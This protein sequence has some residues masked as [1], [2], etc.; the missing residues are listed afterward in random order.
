M[1][2]HSGGRGTCIYKKRISSRK[3]ALA[4]AHRKTRE[5]GELMQAY[6]CLACHSWHIGHAER[7][8]ERERRY[9]GTALGHASR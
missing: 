6:K 2:I 7:Y 4:A 5:L 9:V 8:S 1:R 3:R